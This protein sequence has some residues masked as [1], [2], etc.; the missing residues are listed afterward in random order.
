MTLGEKQEIFS[1][2]VGKLIMFAYENGYGIRLG[3]VYRTKDQQTLYFE[4]YTLKKI[5]SS[6]KLAKITPKSN[7]MNGYH[8]KKLAIDINLFKNGEWLTGKED[9]KLLAEFWS[10]LNPNNV[11]GY[12]WGWD[13][14]HFQMS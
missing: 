11:S 9:F 14:G 3:E 1:E 13:F 12:E 6:V 4:G 2:N 8:L 7:T 10:E 5:G